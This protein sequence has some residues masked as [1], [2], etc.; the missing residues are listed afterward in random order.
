MKVP[1][2]VILNCL[3]IHL[4]IEGDMWP[5]MLIPIIEKTL[6]HSLNHLYEVFSDSNVIQMTWRVLL[7]TQVRMQ[8]LAE[9]EVSSSPPGDAAAPWTTWAGASA[10]H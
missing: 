10:I 2:E 8:T 9:I 3:S 1:N 5:Q 6:Q 4:K 7:K